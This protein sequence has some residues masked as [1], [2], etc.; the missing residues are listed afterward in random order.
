MAVGGGE[1][2]VVTRRDELRRRGHDARLFASN[3]PASPLPSVADYECFG[4]TSRARGLVQ[5]ANPWAAAALR[6]VMRE[7]RPD[8]VHV[9]MFMTQLSPL[10]LPVIRGVPA[11]F[12]AV[13][14][15]YVC[16]T[17]TKMLPTRVPCRSR[18]GAAC[19]TSGCVPLHDW[20]PIMAQHAMARHWRAVF[21]AV[22]AVSD[23]VRDRFAESGVI[24]DDVIPAPIQLRDPRP[25]LAGEPTA[26][27]A[28]RLVP[29]KGTDVLLRAF[30]RVRRQ[31]PAARLTIVGDGPMR[32][33]LECLRHDLGL[34][35][36]VDIHPHMPRPDLERVAD[37]SWVQ[38][39]PSV[40]DEPFGLV[41]AEAMMR[42][43]AVVASRSGGLPTVVG[44]V[45]PGALIPPGDERGLADSLVALLSD[46]D[47]CERVGA[48][49]RRS[50]LERFAPERVVDQL[51][52]HYVRLG[53]A[54]SVS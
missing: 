35:H 3:A 19:L 50:A 12:H 9:N 33:A 44:D 14:Y 27:F 42:G 11:L 37:S 38:V 34:A 18:A 51:F 54:G 36:A 28:G 47:R 7:F 6:R 10:V 22:I 21:G 13:W 16:P 29:D 26:L 49:A 30:S 40:W 20:V 46:R 2:M 8:V 43:S 39:V 17:G 48:A 31:I 25:A 24:V 32:A 4:T 53:A 15:R 45:D 5:S 1:V 23:A 52:A 41:A